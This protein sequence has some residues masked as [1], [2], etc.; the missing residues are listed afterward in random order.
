MKDRETLIQHLRDIIEDSKDSHLPLDVALEGYADA[1]M[2]WY[3]DSD[4]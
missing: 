4:L 1:I 3:E 2:K